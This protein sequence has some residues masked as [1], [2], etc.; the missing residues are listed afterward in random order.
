MNS[1]SVLFLTDK[2]DVFNL[3]LKNGKF[4]PIHLESELDSEALIM[5]VA[6]R[7]KYITN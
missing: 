2:N 3:D 6:V 4:D 5:S 7:L 1:S